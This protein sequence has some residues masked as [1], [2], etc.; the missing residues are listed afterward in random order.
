MAEL[1]QTNS[2]LARDKELNGKLNE[3]LLML[4]IIAAEKRGEVE[5][6]WRLLPE[7]LQ[8]MRKVPLLAWRA[9]ARVVGPISVTSK[10]SQ[11]ERA[12]AARESTIALVARHPPDSLLTPTASSVGSPPAAGEASSSIDSSRARNFEKLMVPLDLSPNAM[13]HPV[14]QYLVTGYI[15]LGDIES[16]LTL[17]RAHISE[18]VSESY[19]EIVRHVLSQPPLPAPPLASTNAPSSQLP[20]I[21]SLLDKIAR[22]NV[23]RTPAYSESIWILTDRGDLP[24]LMTLLPRLEKLDAR[25][26]ESV[27]RLLVKLIAPHQA[28]FDRAAKVGPASPEGS[29]ARCRRAL[30]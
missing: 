16:A 28:E 1:G 29:V 4:Q 12:I 11:K 30:V 6:V 18:H 27:R 23:S 2:V 5:G 24:A 25:V 20:A 9:L 13:K 17:A 10:S 26:I 7:L 19:A 22:A 3:N 15:A 21:F 8:A 14:G